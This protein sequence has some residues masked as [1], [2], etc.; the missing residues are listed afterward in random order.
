R[1][2]VCVVGAGIAGL[3]AAYRL[4]QH[5][6]PVRVFEAQNRVGGRMYSLRNHFA[7]GQVAELGG[8]LI[9]TG[10][11]SI[12]RLASELGIALDDVDA[13]APG[14]AREVWFFGG[15]RRSDAEVVE[16]FRPVAAAIQRD[17][18]TLADDDVTA[19]APNGGEALDRTPLSAWLDRTVG[20]GWFRDLLE[21]A[22]VTEYGLEV[23][24]QSALNLLLMLNHERPGREFRVLGES[25]E[26]YHVRG[27]NDRITTALA[28]RLD[29]AVE[30]GTVLEAVSRRADGTLV[31][32]FQRGSGRM[33]VAA[34]HVI[35]AIPFTLL[36]SVELDDLRLPPDKRR[37]I[38]ALG[39]GTNA[40]LMVGFTG[41]PW[42]E[43]YH[44]AGSTYTDLPYQIT[45][46]ASRAQPGA[47]GVLTNLTGGRRG[48]ALKE[49]TPAEQAARVVAQLERIYPGI[50][51]YRS[52]ATTE[53][54]FH[55][56]TFPWT[57][58]SYA[59]YHPGQWTTLRGVEG[60]SECANT[61]HFAGEHCSLEAQGFME[62]GCE[63]GEAAAHAVLTALHR[64]TR[65]EPASAAKARALAA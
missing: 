40:K 45:W 29:G 52:P 50:G 62:G 49:G 11:A 36:R 18:A 56:P 48:V 39:Y 27:G 58:G 54:R 64:I 10:H 41:R 37:A 3:T 30:T 20:R 22:Y 63:T 65:V 19:D 61:L 31:C 44:T 60:R 9:D 24:R 59:A 13:Y 28:E 15:A 42:E 51:A 53:A 4:R 6:V 26:R 21:V 23:D 5:G 2:N 55:W 12:Q 57:L 7:D 34:R 38:D 33:E 32:A 35:L 17:L 25:D 1:T 46:E 47:S 43:R 16:A 14:A 8:E